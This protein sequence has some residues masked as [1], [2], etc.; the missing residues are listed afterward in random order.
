MQLGRGAAG[1]AAEAVWSMNGLLNL[2]WMPHTG[3]SAAVRECR[4]RGSTSAAAGAAAHY[5]QGGLRT[6][7]PNTEC[8]LPS[9]TIATASSYRPVQQTQHSYLSNQ[10]PPPAMLPAPAKGCVQLVHSSPP[11]PPLLTL[12]SA[13]RSAPAPTTRNHCLAQQL[14]EAHTRSSAAQAERMSAVQLAH[15]Q[16]VNELQALVAMHNG[17]G[18]AGALGRGRPCVF[19]AA[20]LVLAQMC[21]QGVRGLPGVGTEVPAGRAWPPWCWH[22]GACRACVAGLCV[23]VSVFPGMCMCVCVRACVSVRV[24]VCFQDDAGNG[25]STK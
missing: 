11:P 24:C 12:A 2:A 4:H 10:A 15:Q 21:L 3:A 13:Q 9:L 19:V 20:S 18:S 8:K 16:Q 23:C 5:E 22:R 6:P 14:E 7:Q 25:G 1:P 17:G